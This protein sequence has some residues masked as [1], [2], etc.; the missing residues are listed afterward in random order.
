MKKEGPQ[1]RW[2]YAE[3]LMLFSNVTSSL[4]SVAPS[5]YVTTSEWRVLVGI[6]T[7]WISAM[8]LDSA[9]LQDSRLGKVATDFASL[10]FFCK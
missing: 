10:V 2:W 6:F 9:L 8:G 4:T 7:S 5:S 3:R 1:V